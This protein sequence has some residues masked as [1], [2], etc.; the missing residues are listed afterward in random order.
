MSLTADLWKPD[1]P[2]IGV[3][4]AVFIVYLLGLDLF[5]YAQL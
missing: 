2:Y 3:N 5:R 1:S 4:L